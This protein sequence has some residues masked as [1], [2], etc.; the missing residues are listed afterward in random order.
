MAVKKSFQ[1]QGHKDRK[2]REIKKEVTTEC[3]IEFYQRITT[4]INKVYPGAE[5][6]FIGGRR[7]G[8]IESGSNWLR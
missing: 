7:G 6:Q 3:P 2:E 5:L 1:T 8:E 4:E